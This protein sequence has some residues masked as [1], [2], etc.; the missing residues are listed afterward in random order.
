MHV[1]VSLVV[2]VA[3]LGLL[4]LLLQQHFPVGSN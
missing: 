4:L 1:I 3:M 2:Q